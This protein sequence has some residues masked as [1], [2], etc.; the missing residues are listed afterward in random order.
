MSKEVSVYGLDLFGEP[1][2]RPSRGKLAD[3]FVIPPMSIL[4]ART[5]WWLDRKRAWIAQGV[6]EAPSDS[7]AG[8]PGGT[9]S[10]GIESI[11]P[12]VQTGMSIFDPVLCEIMYR[13]FTPVGAQILDPFAGGS[14]RGIVAS[15]L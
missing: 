3:E 15:F 2:K 8:R 14:C 11:K 6:G 1:V 10:N 5:G 4:D 7:A 13:W 9:F 12:G